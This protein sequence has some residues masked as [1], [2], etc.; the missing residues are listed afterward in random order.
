MSGPVPASLGAAWHGRASCV[1]VRH[2]FY[3]SH[4]R[5]GASSMARRG[6]RS[7][8]SWSVNVSLVALRRGELGHVS[9]TTYTVGVVAASMPQGGMD[10][11]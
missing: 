7:V 10:H 6:M 2:A 5:H 8:V 4:G 1:D 3:L 11:G 9:E